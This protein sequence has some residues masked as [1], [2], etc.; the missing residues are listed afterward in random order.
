MLNRYLASFLTA[1]ALLLGIYAPPAM[2]SI[3]VSATSATG[4]VG[5]LVAP[6]LDIGSDG[7]TD[8][9]NLAHITS[10]TFHFSWD[11]TV[12]D[13]FYYSNDPAVSSAPLGTLTDSWTSTDE[14]SDFLDWSS[15]LNIL[16]GFEILRLPDILSELNPVPISFDLTFGSPDANDPYTTIDALDVPPLN[17]TVIPE[18]GSMALV[19][20]ALAGLAIVRRVRTNI[21][22]TL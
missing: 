2:S 19:M 3:T 18:P 1:G 15:G 22:R 4:A 11:P 17:V 12:L 14:N 10:Y 21:T 9:V 8:Q 16:L 5:D 7:D 13:L 6:A 20:L